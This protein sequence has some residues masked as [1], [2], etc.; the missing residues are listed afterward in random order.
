MV[1]ISAAFV[2]ERS[3]PP[4]WIGM[5]RSMVNCSSGRSS[6]ATSVLVVVPG[7]LPAVYAGPPIAH[8]RADAGDCPIDV[9]HAGGNPEE[10]QH[11][12][13][14]RPRTEPVIDG[15]AQPGRDAN[16]D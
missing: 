15:P 8:R 13:P 10:E 1:I 7:V 3:S 14:P 5:M 16:R 2:Y 9:Q 6:I 12:N 11:D 4:I